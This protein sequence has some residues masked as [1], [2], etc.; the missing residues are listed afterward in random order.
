MTEITYDA[1]LTGGPRDGAL[2]R[3]DGEAM[4]EVEIDGLLHR[5]RITTKDRQHDGASLTV[6]TYD[7]VIDPS[8]AQPGV[9]TPETGIGRPVDQERLSH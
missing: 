6:Y 7:G 9:E 3:S 2:L 5:Y 1:V 8:G 4:V